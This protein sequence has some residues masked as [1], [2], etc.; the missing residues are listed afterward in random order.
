M[1]SLKSG[2][3]KNSK[4]DKYSIWKAVNSG[5][6]SLNIIDLQEQIISR[7]ID[8]QKNHNQKPNVISLNKDRHPSPKKVVLDSDFAAMTNAFFA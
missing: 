8:K 5:S 4:K 2:N 6:S 7:E 3:D 1:Q